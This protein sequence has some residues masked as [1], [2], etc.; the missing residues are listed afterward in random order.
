MAVTYADEAYIRTTRERIAKYRQDAAS[1][2]A[3]AD[4]LEE[5]LSEYIRSHQP[6]AKPA[7][8][9]P[10]ATS[11]TVTF[12]GGGTAHHVVPGGT[13]AIRTPEEGGR[14][15]MLMDAIRLN[16]KGYTTDDLVDMAGKWGMAVRR[17]TLRSQLWNKRKDGKL[18]K[19][20]DRWIAKNE[21]PNAQTSG[22][23]H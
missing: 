10:A 7:P 18:G 1:A 20:K 19:R 4:A 14:I 13:V 6:F 5:N 16:P 2:T 21:E 23:S 15:A 9:A 22:S 12:A 11:N 17:E 8:E 3:V